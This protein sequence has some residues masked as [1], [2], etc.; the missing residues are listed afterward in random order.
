MHLAKEKY[1]KVANLYSSC[2]KGDFSI[3]EAMFTIFLSCTLASHGYCN[4]I[5]ETEYLKQ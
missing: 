1:A 4:K 3:A 2:V 5:P